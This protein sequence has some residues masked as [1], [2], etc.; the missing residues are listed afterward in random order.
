MDVY[1][2]FISVYTSYNIVDDKL[3]C[4]IYCEKN[5]LQGIKNLWHDYSNIALGA[6]RPFANHLYLLWDYWQM[7]WGRLEVPL[8]ASLAISSGTIRLKGKG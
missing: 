2:G 7:F 3:F 8:Y 1:V 6:G 4:G 5:R